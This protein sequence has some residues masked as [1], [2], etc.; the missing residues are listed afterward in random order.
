LLLERAGVTDTMTYSPLARKAA[1]NMPLLLMVLV[2]LSLTAIGGVRSYLSRSSGFMTQDEALYYMS[3]LLSLDSGRLILTYNVRILFQL[4]L[5]GFSYVFGIRDGFSFLT[6]GPILP[7]FFSSITVVLLYLILKEANLKQSALALSIFS[8]P[9][10]FVFSLMT[11]FILTEAPA[12]TMTMLGIYLSLLSQR[13]NTALLTILS[14]TSFGLAAAFRETFALY[15][16]VAML[17]PLKIIYKKKRIMSY[18]LAVLMILLVEL[19]LLSRIPQSLTPSLLLLT[20]TLQ[21][22]TIGVGYGWSP[23]FAFLALS[24]TATLGFF[25]SR[26]VANDRAGLYQAL[27][28]CGLLSQI[29]LLI[30]YPI[31]FIT[32]LNPQGRL[33]SQFT[34]G[35]IRWS[36]A[37]LPGAFLSIS[38]GCI[39]LEWA[40][41]SLVSRV[42][43]SLKIVQPRRLSVIFVVFIVVSAVWNVYKGPTALAYSQSALAEEPMVTSGKYTPIATGSLNQ[44]LFPS[45]MSDPFTRLRTD[46]KSQP[47]RL[48]NYVKDYGEKNPDS[49][50]LVIIGDVWIH[51]VRARVLLHGMNNVMIVQ[52]PEDWYS[53]YAM[54][55]SYDLVLLYG[56]YYGTYYTQTVSAVPHYYLQVLANQTDIRVVRVWE[57]QEGYL[58]RLEG[59]VSGQR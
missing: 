28:L 52:P 49:K 31:S 16:F 13:R 37:G 8:V 3:V 40:L 38:Y 42:T 6:W 20:A 1:R 51:T 39:G 30:E 35:F 24:G 12:L 14:L 5:L 26:R 57:W 44:S 34:S 36:F 17:V 7:V 41:R 59:D 22:Y 11:G 2:I 9:L 19:V 32:I 27:F 55:S 45:S 18:L 10:F 15:G 53:F 56:E 54:A 33:V 58:Y 47:F 48:Y 21:A 46:Y 43:G 29:T 23:P 4:L 25:A 50:I